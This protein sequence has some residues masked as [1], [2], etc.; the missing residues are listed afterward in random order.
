MVDP[1]NGYIV[2]NKIIRTE[3]KSQFYEILDSIE[4]KADDTRE[5]NLH[6]KQVFQLL[7]IK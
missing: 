1:Y 3:S 6:M 4:R 2:N 5:Q 7:L